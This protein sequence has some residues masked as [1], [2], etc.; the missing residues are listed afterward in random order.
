MVLID[1]PEKTVIESPRQCCRRYRKLYDFEL[2][3]GGGH[4]RGTVSD[5]SMGMV[6]QALE[7]LLARDILQKI[8]PVT[9][10]PA[11]TTDA[12]DTRQRSCSGCLPWRRNHSLASAKAH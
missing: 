5:E 9:A 7:A 4:A 12:A 8:F 3:Q 6:A 11:N 2:M 1:D 10:R